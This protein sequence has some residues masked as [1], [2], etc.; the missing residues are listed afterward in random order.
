MAAEGSLQNFAV[1]RAIEERAPLLQ[2]AYAFRGFLGVKL[3]H[4]PVVQKFPAAHGVTKVRT[5]VVCRVYIRHRRR[6]AA[7]SHYRV[8][9]AK[10]GFAHYTDRYA[11]GQGLN[12]CPQARASRADDEYV[13]LVGFV[14]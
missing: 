6:D 7:F 13:V 10:Q 9:F 1:L 11:L 8:R 2:F 14:C 3:G 5:P 4:T 12:S